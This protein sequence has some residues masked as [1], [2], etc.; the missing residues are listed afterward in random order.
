VSELERTPRKPLLE[1]PNLGRESINQEDSG[2]LNLRNVKLARANQNAERTP[3]ANGVQRK[4]EWLVL[5]RREQR[6]SDVS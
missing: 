2:T 3:A 5:P 1:I 4:K 6:V